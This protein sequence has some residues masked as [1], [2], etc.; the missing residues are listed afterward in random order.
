MSQ[1]ASCFW[2]NGRGKK[3]MLHW[4]HRLQWGGLLP[5][6]RNF[7]DRNG[8]MMMMSIAHLKCR[9]ILQHQSASH[10]ESRKPALWPMW[11]KEDTSSGDM[12]AESCHHASLCAFIAVRQINPDFSSGNTQW[13][14]QGERKQHAELQTHNLPYTVHF[15]HSAR[16]QA[17]PTFL[18][19]GR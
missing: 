13:V 4:D 15:C 19:R 16:L 9:L 2:G 17:V 12:K 1:K 3:N 8:K 5:L 18:P 6:E 14:L 7:E 11:D 10:W